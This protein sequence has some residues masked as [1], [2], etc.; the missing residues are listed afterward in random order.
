MLTLHRIC[1]L[2]FLLSGLH[3]FAQLKPDTTFFQKFYKFEGRDEIFVP[4][5]RIAFADS[6]YYFKRGNPP[7]KKPYNDPENGLGEP[8]FTTYVTKKPKYVSIGCGG[9]YAVKFKEVGFID[10]EGP[11]LVFF[12]V[13]PSLE[14]FKVEI[15]TDGVNWLQLGSQ[16]NGGQTTVDIGRFVRKT[17]PPQIFQYIR[18]TDLKAS[19]GGPTPGAD[20]DAI[21]AIG[22]VIKL[23]LDA[24]VLFDY[25]KFNI[26]ESAQKP[27]DRL[28]SQL[29]EIPKAEIQISGHTDGDGSAAYNMVLGKNRANS[30]SRYIQNGM[31][32][33]G[34][35]TY[36]IKSF[37]KSKPVAE[38]QSDDG[39]Q[40]NRRVEILV[41]PDKDFYKPPRELQKE[42]KK[43]KR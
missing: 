28:I 34:D 26:R 7:A 31:K 42:K 30:V 25:D 21:G 23:S 38:N 29:Q 18:L 10:I 24:M 9:Q 11:D 43:K 6:L 41:F 4:L 1:I 3:S 8:D 16:V 39:K 40:K 27:L 32:G 2:V 15:S 35:F 33:K 20:I 36:K 37:G 19:C 13:G 17:D 22:A 12:E 5:G 14:P